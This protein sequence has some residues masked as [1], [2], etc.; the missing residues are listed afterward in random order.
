MTDDKT[1]GM[2]KEELLKLF[3]KL[4][5]SKYSNILNSI[6]LNINPQMI[7][8]N[9]AMFERQITQF[10]NTYVECVLYPFASEII[11]ANNKR[12][13]EDVEK[14]LSEKCK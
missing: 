10:W 8:S 14:L 6:P 4:D 11:E 1:I 13:K 2:S 5:E 3:N 7:L 9:P 12:V